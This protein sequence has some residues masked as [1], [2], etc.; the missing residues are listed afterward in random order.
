MN[1]LLIAG[2]SIVT[3]ALIFY[4]IGILT[5]QRRKQLSLFVLGFVTAGVVCDI[6]GTLLMIIGSGFRVLTLHGLIGY[7]ALGGMLADTL[8]LWKARKRNQGSPSRRLHLYT[9]IAYVWWIVAYLSG[10]IMSM[11]R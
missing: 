10:V 2:S 8:L 7:T 11:S 4:S 9:R 5:E 6:S 1:A 3:L